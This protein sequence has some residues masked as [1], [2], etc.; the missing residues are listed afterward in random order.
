MLSIARQK[1]RR[2]VGFS[3]S[4]I[5]KL[6]SRLSRLQRS[7]F[8]VGGFRVIRVHILRISLLIR[9][10]VVMFFD[11]IHVIQKH[12]RHALKASMD[13]P[14]FLLSRLPSE[15][16]GESIVSKLNKSFLVFC[17]FGHAVV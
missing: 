5:V 3:S 7:S 6:R 12:E 11:V 2:I 1:S 10:F 13:F 8:L 4:R 14:N 16:F 15:N 17:W 9:I